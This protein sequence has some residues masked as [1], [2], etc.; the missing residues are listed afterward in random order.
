MRRMPK[1]EVEIQV[2]PMLDMAFQLL[3]FF[4]LT[5]RPVPTEGQFSMNLLP[6]APSADIMSKQE[7]PGE[8]KAN[9]D[10]PAALRTLNTLIYAS[11][12]GGIAR[13]VIGENEFQTL[14]Q[15][16]ARLIEIKADES[17][18]FEQAVIQSDP[19]LRYEELMKV[20][21]VFADDKV[22]ITQ[23]DFKELN[24]S[25]APAL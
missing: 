18:K 16:E 20:I 21:N 13:M 25:G 22:G 3:T 11:A 19:A 17:L 2:T 15:L 5:Y 10:I 7:E 12:D 24:P 4:I 6:S 23:I 8:A 1:G 14:E 9:A